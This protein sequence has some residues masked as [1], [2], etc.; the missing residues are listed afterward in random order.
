[1]ELA[2]QRLQLRL[3]EARLELRGPQRAVLRLPKVGRS[4]AESDD[5]A[6]RHHLPVEIHDVVSLDALPPG[7][8]PDIPGARH[9]DKDPLDEGH[10]HEYQHENSAEM[11][12]RRALPCVALQRKAARH[13]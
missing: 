8:L 6:I 11:H 2:L 3:G 1:M 10:V 5:R 4:M 13:P 7:Q 12:G 9:G